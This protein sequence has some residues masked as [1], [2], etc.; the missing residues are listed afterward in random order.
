[1]PRAPEPLPSPREQAFR[2]AAQ[3]L[4]A[5]VPL[6]QG[7]RE[8]WR[9]HLTHRDA[10]GHSLCFAN[11]ERMVLLDMTLQGPYLIPYALEHVLYEER[12]LE[13]SA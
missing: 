6:P 3:D 12:W 8:R 13:P 5:T 7:L 10:Y 1:M 11:V 2:V 4:L 9:E